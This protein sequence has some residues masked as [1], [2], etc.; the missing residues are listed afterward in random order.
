LGP[1]RDYGGDSANREA[2]PILRAFK[3]DT[4]GTIRLHWASEM[5]REPTDPE[6]DMRHMGTVEPVWTLFDLTPG[7]RP[8]KDEQIEYDCC[9]G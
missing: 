5:V 1:V 2:V 7:G 3:R 9:G 8:A 4:E 6:Q